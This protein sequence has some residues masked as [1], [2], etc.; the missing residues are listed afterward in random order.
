[1][2]NETQWITM[3]VEG[4]QVKVHSVHKAQDKVELKAAIRWLLLLSVVAP[5]GERLRGKGSHGVF[6]V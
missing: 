6:A 4:K 2:W 3:N 5:S 1:V